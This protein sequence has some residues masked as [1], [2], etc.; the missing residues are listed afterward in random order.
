[1]IN[2]RELFHH[3]QQHRANVYY[4]HCVI[5][6]IFIIRTF[7]GV[8]VPLNNQSIDQL[9]VRDVVVTCTWRVVVECTTL[10]KVVYMQ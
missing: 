6:A 5:Y 7:H 3:G 8:D 9:F 4:I 1:V 10:F 2:R